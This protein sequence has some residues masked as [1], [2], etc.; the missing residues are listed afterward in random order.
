MFVI[1]T[2]RLTH[3]LAD[4]ART[5][6]CLRDLENEGR[7]ATVTDASGREVQPSDLWL[8]AQHDRRAA[9]AVRE[10]NPQI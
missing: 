8:L 9:R 1:R 4:A 6:S 2:A 10:G 7:H 5:Y 3:G